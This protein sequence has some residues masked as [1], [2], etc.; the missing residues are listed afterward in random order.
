MHDLDVRGARRVAL[1]REPGRV[2]ELV[3]ACADAA[4]DV[5]VTAERVISIQIGASCE[6]PVAAFAKI[7][8]TS[9]ALNTYVGGTDMNLRRSGTSQR[10]DGMQLAA[11]L[12]QE[13]LDGGAAELLKK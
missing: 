10:V 11:S 5:P 6:L 9:L 2:E 8:G 13:L 12:A 4:P 1:L 7:D 3:R